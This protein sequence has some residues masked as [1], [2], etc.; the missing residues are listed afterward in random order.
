MT[1]ST[2]TPDLK[3]LTRTARD[4]AATADQLQACAGQRD[5]IDRL[6][7]KRPNASAQLLEQL[8][9]SSDRATRSAAS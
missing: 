5:A 3:A 7:A 8:S 2:S 9:H 4:P 1:E 6:L